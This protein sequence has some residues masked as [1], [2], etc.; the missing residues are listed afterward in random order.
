M[1]TF[2]DLRN[3][4]I[5]KITDLKKKG[6]DPYPASVIRKQIISQARTLDGKEVSVVGRIMGMRGQGKINFLDLVD[7][8]GKI[9][10]VVKHDQ[11]GD[12]EIKLLPLLDIGD[13]IS[14]GGKVGKTQAGEISVFAEK[15]QIICK[16]IRPMP[17]KWHGL[18]D[19]EER[20]R[21]RY[22]DMLLNPHV[23]DTLKIR[24]AAIEAIREYLNKQGF[25]EVETPTLQP[26]YGGGF[27]KPFKT[28]HN[29]LD[30]DFYL[31]I[32]DEMYLK[33]LIV[34][35]FEKVYEITKVFRNEGIDFDHNPEFTMFEA[36]IAFEDYRY[37]MDIIE[38]IIE[39]ITKKVL[40]KTSFEYQGI[41]LDVKSPWQ[42][43]SYVDAI[44]K[45]TGIKVLDWK[46]IE[47][48]KQAIRKL[49]IEEKRMSML[50]KMHSLG[51]LISFVFEEKIEENLIQPTIIYDYPVEISPLAKK[52]DNPNFTQRFE[53]FAM[54][55]E[56]GNNYSELNDPL[57][58]YQ[59]FIEEKKREKAGF[60]EAHQT[61][62]DYLTAIEHGFPPT[63][64]IAIGIDRLIMLFT[65]SSSI[66]EV[67]A[68]PTLRPVDTEDTKSTE[69]SS[70]QVNFI[71]KP[72]NQSNK[73]DLGISYTKAKELVNQYIT[74]KFTKLHLRES[75][76]IMRTL[77][78]QLG[79]DV[80]SWGIIGLLHDI[81]WEL[82]KDNTKLH[83]IKTAEI[84]KEVGGTDFLIETIQSHGYG[85]GWGA[86]YYGPPEFEGKE[87]KGLIQHAL[88]A[89]ETLTGLI[90][91][92]ALVQPDK[93]LTSVKLDSLKKKFKSKNFA[94]NC[95]RDIMMECEKLGL[96][97]D[98]FLEIG[99]KALQEIHEEIGL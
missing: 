25:I 79:Q 37:G 63:C 97:L 87:R 83:C 52:C 91:A 88:A 36:Q 57:D 96:T 45:Y 13:F 51:E 50:D 69:Q 48:A 32:S 21:K 3:T 73:K 66:K 17:D 67:I 72:I 19:I 15:I 23:V 44:E 46:T 27:A 89:A 24:S 9:Q 77:A 93:K 86:N 2:E 65:N 78:K 68:F 26:I 62:Y 39:Y 84:L 33:R 22:I 94:A 38:K 64:G 28:H 70:I 40:G 75:E 80:E 34:G 47:Q 61:D 76:A 41:K 7:E 10:I 85:Q 4:R 5:K 56:L 18:K 98:Q 92:S 74:D 82:T 30:K 42:R 99:L 60:E 54:G 1:S 58:L 8:S 59:R 20:Y 49:D 90:I 31:R 12:L 95:N 6:I 16:A 55:S 53:M 29:A 81:D 11:V 14:V 43:L 35:G 71:Q